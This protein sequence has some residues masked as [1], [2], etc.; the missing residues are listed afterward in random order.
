MRY[1]P[2]AMAEKIKTAILT[3][4]ERYVP[5]V[6]QVKTSRTGMNHYI[7]IVD[8]FNENFSKW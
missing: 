4:N 6:H 7:N 3:K 8:Y 1:D 2:Q 5:Y